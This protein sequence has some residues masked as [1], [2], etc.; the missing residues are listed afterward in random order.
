M[1]STEIL[2]YERRVEVIKR[3]QSCLLKGVM[4]DTLEMSR[5]LEFTM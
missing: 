4:H 1:F 5:I 3:K 2:E